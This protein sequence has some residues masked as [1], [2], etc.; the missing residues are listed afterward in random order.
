MNMHRISGSSCRLPVGQRLSSH[1]VCL[2]SR[3]A[4]NRSRD[5]HAA[6]AAPTAPGASRAELESM[7]VR[8]EA[9]L[10]RMFESGAPMPKAADVAKLRSEVAALA[11]QLAGR[12][13]QPL[14]EPSRGNQTVP[15]GAVG[16]VAQP[17]RPR[18]KTEEMAFWAYEQVEQQ[19]RSNQG[20]GASDDAEVA[21]LEADNTQ[22]RA[23]AYDLL[24]RQQE[25]ETLL[26][27]VRGTKQPEM[28]LDQTEGILARMKAKL[29]RGE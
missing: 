22:L 11:D 13:V 14:V 28:L 26:A 16:S 29:Q 24:K 19:M 25:L 10:A 12:P 3:V 17:N 20:M 18:S 21:R 8:K 2:S 23:Q 7:L 9:E 1:T 27:E 6:R 15:L 4:R 5:H